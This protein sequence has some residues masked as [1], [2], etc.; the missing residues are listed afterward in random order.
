MNQRPAPLVSVIIPAHN[1]ATT[2]GR[3]LDSVLR[4]DY[5]PLEIIVIDDASSDATG[6]VV[7]NR[8]HPDVRVIRLPSQQGASAARNAGI[9]AACG[10]LVAFLDA[11]DEWLPRK[12]SLQVAQVQANERIV[13]VCCRATEVAS[14]G[15]PLGTVNAGKTPVTGANV[16]RSLL[17]QNFV[18]TP[19]VL[20]RR[21]L[22]RELGGFDTRLRIA[23][24]QDMW[25]RLAALG[26]VAYVDETL[27]IV[28]DRP[29]S[30]SKSRVAD[31]LDYTLPMIRS[32]LSR[33]R[34]QLSRREIGAILGERYGEIGRSAY[35]HKMYWLGLSL[36][37]RSVLLGNR[38]FE[39][40]CFLI[41]SSPP[42][43]WLKRLVRSNS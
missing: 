33:F 29:Q 28:H 16:W 12:T 41:F 2:I 5:R 21:T 20:A 7:L 18:A 31:Q 15:T 39:N 43:I 4:Q 10:E 9:E 11:D 13:F 37:G 27:V 38:P 40:L 24:D 35:N 42:A 26:E 22:L 8:R 6:D 14:D 19:C 3:A 30:L 36:I 1:A 32:H 34:D 17:A 25:I 23:E